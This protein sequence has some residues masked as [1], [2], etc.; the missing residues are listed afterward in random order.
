MP[1]FVNE[2]EQAARRNQIIDIAQQLVYTK[3][4]E[5]MTIQDILDALQISKGAFYHY[6]GSKQELLEALVE[7]L[8][9]QASQLQDP[10]LQAPNLNALEKLKQYFNTIG[11]W[12][13]EHKA[14]LLKLLRVWYNDEN[15]L[16]RQK[17]HAASLQRFAPVLTQIIRQGMQ[18]GVLAPHYPEQAGDV[19]LALML[20]LGEMLAWSLITDPPDA[21]ALPRL[22]DSVAAYQ[23]AIERI[24]GAPP[25]SVHLFDPAILREWMIEKEP[26]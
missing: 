20:T 18:E 3:G 25:G 21:N 4:Y 10:I 1:R 19:V 8:V 15:A 11:R 22:A 26:D 2:A 23:D 14:Y 12:K 5:Q 24:L 16:V 17:L 6:F 13:T 9:E 7:R